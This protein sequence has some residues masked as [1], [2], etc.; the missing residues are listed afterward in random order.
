MST[1]VIRGPGELI[2]VIPA[3]LGYEPRESVVA[4]GLGR[5]GELGAVMRADRPD[6][7]VSD[8]AVEIHDRMRARLRA[9]GAA[10]AVVVSFTAAAVPLGCPAA[11]ALAVALDGVVDR[12]DVWTCDGENYRVPGCTDPECCSAAGTPV[13][14]NTAATHGSARWREQC[15]DAPVPASAVPAARAPERERRRAARAGDRWWARRDEE[16]WRRRSL[17][18][19]IASV[20]CPGDPLEMGRATVALRDV[21]VRDGL[22]VWLL[23]GAEAAVDD[24]LEGRAT[25]KVAGVLDGALRDPDRRPASTQPLLDVQF[26]CWEAES[27]A[28]RRDA[29]P[30]HAVDGVAAWWS[31]DIRDAGLAAA[32]ALAC[33]P[34]YT[35]AGLIADVCAAGLVPAWCRTE[36]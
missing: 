10:R 14:R 2:A 27:H 7:L 35:L 29:A 3:I 16:A 24:V 1:R 20:R 15:L 25:A 36:D 13:P 33:D 18:M 8:L 30:F 6:L 9:E 4:I 11:D 32:Q 17:D 23:G 5:G 12:V 34:E 22:I 26:W 28:R 31:G 19:V 21:R